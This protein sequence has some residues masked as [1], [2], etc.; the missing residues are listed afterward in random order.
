[1][2]VSMLYNVSDKIIKEYGTIGGM[3]IA[4]ETKVP[5]GNLPQ[6]YSVHHHK[7]HMI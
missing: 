7:S 5:R 1:M 4:K 2:S 6:C 3:R